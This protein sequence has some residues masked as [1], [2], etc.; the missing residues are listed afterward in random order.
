MWKSIA[1]IKYSYKGTA[2]LFVPG[3][4]QKAVLQVQQDDADL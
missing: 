4:E 1:Y 2:L 3:K